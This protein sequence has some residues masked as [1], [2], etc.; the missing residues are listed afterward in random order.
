MAI[1]ASRG[2]SQS[3]MVFECADVTITNAPYPGLGG[4]ARKATKYCPTGVGYCGVPIP[5]GADRMSFEAR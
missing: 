2:L 1:M 5:T 4:A 3:V